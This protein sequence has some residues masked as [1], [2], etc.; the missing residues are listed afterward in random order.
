MQDTFENA[1][2]GAT[3]GS[4]KKRLTYK[5]AEEKGSDHERG[6]GGTEWEHHHAQRRG[7]QGNVGHNQ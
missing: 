3:Q 1:S 2:E 4:S 7:D 6:V 5:E